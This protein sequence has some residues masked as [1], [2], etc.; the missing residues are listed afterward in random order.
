MIKINITNTYHLLQIP[1]YEDIITYTEALRTN[2]PNLTTS[3]LT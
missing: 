1:Q 2:N 3:L